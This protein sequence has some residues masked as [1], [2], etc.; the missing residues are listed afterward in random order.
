MRANKTV[1]STIKEMTI[2]PIV[3]ANAADVS[4]EYDANTMSL[5]THKPH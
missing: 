3:P 2:I 4:E 5:M 1:D